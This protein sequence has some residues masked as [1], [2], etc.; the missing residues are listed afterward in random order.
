MKS[1]YI[2]VI[3]IFGLSTTLLIVGCP[4]DPEV[5]ATREE[6]TSVTSTVAQR[7]AVAT[8]KIPSISQEAVTASEE[9][10]IALADDENLAKSLKKK[11]ARIALSSSE[12]VPESCDLPTEKDEVAKAKNLSDIKLKPNSLYTV[13]VCEPQKD[14]KKFKKT[15]KTKVTKDSIITIETSEKQ[16]QLTSEKVTIQDLTDQTTTTKTTLKEEDST[17]FEKTAVYPMTNAEIEDAKKQVSKITDTAETVVTEEVSESAVVAQTTF[18]TKA[19]VPELKEVFLEAAKDKPDL[20]QVTINTKGNP[21]DTEYLLVGL[22]AKGEMVE[23]G[24]TWQVP[25]EKDSDPKDDHQETLMSLS[26]NEELKGLSLVARNL[27]GQATKDITIAVEMDNSEADRSVITFEKE[28]LPAPPNLTPSTSEVTLSEEATKDVDPDS[29]AGKKEARSTAV[30]ARA[31]II[32]QR[33]VVVDQIKSSKKNLK[34]VKR[35]ISAMKKDRAKLDKNI[36]KLRKKKKSLSAEDK[37][38]L[39]SLRKEKSEVIIKIKTKNKDRKA[40]LKE[41]KQSQK[42]RKNL[43][44]HIKKQRKKIKKLSAQ[45][46]K[47]KKVERKKNQAR[48]KANKDSTLKAKKGKAKLKKTAQN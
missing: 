6:T 38:N 31:E 26:T 10:I 4:N 9:D 48:K 46:K 5:T 40:L 15:K 21:S 14:G 18:H 19:S 45:I 32:A 39:A 13:A 30:A 7:R 1:V 35:E 12:E 3:K 47:L 43:S 34:I 42:E 22:D 16:N 27:D 11:G 37:T 41:I 44:G 25:V 20:Y 2:Q 36:K 33:K 24:E 29:I 8:K 17:L 28:E 23:T